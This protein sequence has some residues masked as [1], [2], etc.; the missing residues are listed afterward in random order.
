MLSAVTLGGA[1]GT[2][3]GA[4]GM[5]Y[6]F[7]HPDYLEPGHAKPGVSSRSARICFLRRLGRPAN[8]GAAVTTSAFVIFGGSASLH[9]VFFVAMEL[10]AMLL[11]ARYAWTWSPER[12]AQSLGQG[13]ALQGSIPSQP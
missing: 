12:E 4:S 3:Y 10:V 7:F 11:I 9:Y 8:A 2:E 13:S 5:R 6:L 1:Y